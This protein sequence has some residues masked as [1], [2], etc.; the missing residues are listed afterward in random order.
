MFQVTYTPRRAWMYFKL[1]VEAGQER[2]VTGTSGAVIVSIYHQ[3]PVIVLAYM[4]GRYIFRTTI[5]YNHFRQQDEGIA[6]I[7][8]KVTSVPQFCLY[9]FPWF[10][11][12]RETVSYG[13]LLDSC[14]RLERGLLY[15]FY[16]SSFYGKG[17]RYS[18]HL[19][20]DLSKNF[21]FLPNSD[22]RFYQDRGDDWFGQ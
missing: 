10:L 11:A 5:D 17:F 14:L 9:T 6:L 19:R 15:T 2:D 7:D 16:N 20:Y 22:E 21:M 13:R 1:S 12:C 4:P 3:T 8:G 18:A